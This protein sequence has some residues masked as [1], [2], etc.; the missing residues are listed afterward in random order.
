MSESIWPTIHAERQ[1]LADDLAD[2]TPEQWAT[3]T[4]CPDWNVHQVLAHQ[5]TAATM[6]PPRFFLKIAA[7]DHQSYARPDQHGDSRPQ[8]PIAATGQRTEP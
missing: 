8:Q 6:T 4:M 5:L 3:P 2:L 1:A 7:A